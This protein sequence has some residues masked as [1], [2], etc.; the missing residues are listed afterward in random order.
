MPTSAPGSTSM[1]MSLAAA[2]ADAKVMEA[3]NKIVMRIE[4]DPELSAGL[5]CN[6]ILDQAPD[7]L[8]GPLS[9][10]GVQGSA[11]R[12]GAE[13]PSKGRTS[14]RQGA[15]G[16]AAKPTPTLAHM[17][18]AASSEAGEGEFA[19]LDLLSERDPD[20]YEGRPD[21]AL[22]PRSRGL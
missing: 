2:Q 11:P 3:F 4:G 17:P 21:Q 12:Q 14:G 13:K 9:E 20:A 18:A 10:G 6:Q 19:S 8:Q 16:K 15:A 1:P 7:H 22:C 5:N